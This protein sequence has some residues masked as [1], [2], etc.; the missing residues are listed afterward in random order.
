[1]PRFYALRYDD[2]PLTFRNASSIFIYL[3]ADCL[4]FGTSSDLSYKI[5]MHNKPICCY[6]SH[7][8]HSTL[9][10]RTIFVY[11]HRH[12]SQSDHRQSTLTDLGF[13]MVIPVAI[14]LFRLTVTG[15][16]G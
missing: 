1:M 7:Y 4:S 3:I 16:T 11:K 8:F 6:Y 2:G 14:S 5:K 15:S 9:C 13:M 10:L 12:L